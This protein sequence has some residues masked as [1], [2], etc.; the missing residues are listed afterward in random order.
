MFKDEE[1]TVN[2]ILKQMQPLV[3]K[4]NAYLRS[5]NITYQ[6]IKWDV[7]ALESKR[8]AARKELEMIETQ[9]KIQ[10]DKSNSIIAMANEEAK[11]ILQSAGEKNV[12]AQS[13]LEDVR[14]FVSG[15]DKK[16]YQELKE[17][18]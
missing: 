13:L 18:V 12:K 15:I 14:S 2:E 5:D 11:K 6:T 3:E 1:I 8:T 17:K 9:K 16:K 7:G 4:L 10:A